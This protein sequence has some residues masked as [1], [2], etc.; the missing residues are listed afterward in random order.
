MTSTELPRLPR[1]PL[2]A[3]P[4]PPLRA[5]E[6]LPGP[7]RKALT[8]RLRTLVATLTG[9]EAPANL[10]ALVAAVEE[11]VAAHPDRLWLARSVVG[12]ELPTDVEM[13]E[14]LVRARL[15]GAWAALGPTLSRLE[16]QRSHREVDVVRDA[17]VCDV[18]GTAR[19]D[20][21]SGIQRVVRE[22]TS[23]WHRDHAVEFVAWTDDHTA[24]RRLTDSERHRLLGQAAGEEVGR[25]PV[26][27][28][29]ESTYAGVEL[30]VDPPRTSRLLPLSKHSRN[31]VAYIG[32]DC[33][34]VLSS[35]M[36][37]VSKVKPGMTTN[38]AHY[39]AA[40]RDA[41]RVGAISAA[42]AEEFIG[43]A[44]M[45]AGRGSKGPDVGVVPL[46]VVAQDV[47]PADLAEARSLLVLGDT[48]MIL[49]VG[50]H[51]VRKNHLAVLHA[52]ETLWREGR[53][54]TL[55]LVG[56]GSFGSGDYDILLQRLVAAGRP[57]QSIRG[58]E[59]RLLWAA[60]RLA[61]FTVFPSLNEGFGLPIAESL[62]V[63]TP[64]VTSGFGSMRD[65]VAPDGEP[66]G[67]LLVD[68]RDDRSLIAAMRTMLT[69]KETY[70][71]L[72]AETSR[73]RERTW[74]EYASEL[75]DFLVEGRHPA[76]RGGE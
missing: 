51:E 46:A 39:L 55:T 15:N 52:A 43:W 20:Y 29:W 9:A 2:A 73:H 33:I 61:R 27:V 19:S 49:V 42:A 8:A 67:G 48:P 70:A 6:R 32:Y 71:R 66:L 10:D 13:V 60:Y 18:H 59:D 40:C 47:R 57:V 14:I 56:A 1:L 3:P 69:D 12:A 16:R 76:P 53:R 23:R 24:L 25:T 45:C 58:L 35:S 30:V 21:L 74:D 65:I 38:F 4:A 36:V 75:W 41:D 34:P 5:I 28:P 26:V 17:V 63:G 68:P 22:T 11:H 62:A 54:F 72:V 64:V 7:A 31:E 37:T 50:N 44:G